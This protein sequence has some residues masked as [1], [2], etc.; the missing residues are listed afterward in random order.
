MINTEWIHLR[1]LDCRVGHGFI[2]K[3]P[4]SVYTARIYV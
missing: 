1:A 4:V 2:N 3:T